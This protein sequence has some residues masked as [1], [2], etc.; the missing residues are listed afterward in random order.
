MR[1]MSAEERA[2]RSARLGFPERQ[3]PAFTH[4][5]AAEQL[6]IEVEQASRWRAVLA[7]ARRVL[8]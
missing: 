1:G 7:M 8:R 3:D 4:A 2:D 5:L 6:L